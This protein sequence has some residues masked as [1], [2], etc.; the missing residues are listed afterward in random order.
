[1][2][3]LYQN[4]Y[5]EYLCTKFILKCKETS[6]C[7]S[8][9]SNFFFFLKRHLTSKAESQRLPH[10][11]FHFIFLR[12]A[13]KHR[14]V[15]SHFLIFLWV[16]FSNSA[17]T[18]QTTPLQFALPI[19]SPIRTLMMALWVWH[20]WPLPNRDWEGSALNVRISTTVINGI[21]LNSA[22]LCTLILSYSLLSIILCQETQLPEHWLD[23]H[24]E[25]WEN[26]SD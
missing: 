20:T 25:L 26:N 17:M 15:D 6:E 3:Q 14:F 2:A 16:L 18:S 8:L 21:P 7:P 12:G 13:P 9:S 11:F 24:H 5:I 10:L 22:W 19:S 1:M 4:H 23:K